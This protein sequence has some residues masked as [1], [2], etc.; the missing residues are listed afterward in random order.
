MV[1][2]LSS[3]NI[4]TKGWY[5]VFNSYRN[6]LGEIAKILLANNITHMEN[7][8][9]KHEGLKSMPC[10]AVERPNAELEKEGGE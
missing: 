4:Q 10:S 9:P 7:L 8:E 1:V 3:Y 2:T 6:E 5:Y